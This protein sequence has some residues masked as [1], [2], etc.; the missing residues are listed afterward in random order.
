MIHFE[1]KCAI[2]QIKVFI[3]LIKHVIHWEK[4]KCSPLFSQ[5]EIGWTQS[6]RWAPVLWLMTSKYF[7]FYL[8]ILYRINSRI[9]FKSVNS[10]FH[11]EDCVHVQKKMYAYHST[12]YPLTTVCMYWPSYNSMPQL[13]VCASYRCIVASDNLNSTHVQMLWSIHFFVYEADMYVQSNMPMRSLLL[14]SH[15]Y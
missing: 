1:I 15:L 4:I 3:I 7:S 5:L 6:S 13:L 8:D 14:S 9:W 11:F 2:L 12:N 10:N